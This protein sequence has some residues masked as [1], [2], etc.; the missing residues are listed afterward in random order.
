MKIKINHIRPHV[1]LPVNAPERGC[2]GVEGP[3]RSTSNREAARNFQA[4]SL[5]RAVDIRAFPT[6]RTTDFQSAACPPGFHNQKSKIKNQKFLFP[7]SNTFAE[8]SF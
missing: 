1:A 3:S 4:R 7:L 8:G 5:Q 6:L 2:G